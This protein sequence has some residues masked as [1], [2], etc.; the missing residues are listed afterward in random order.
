MEE[1]ENAHGKLPKGEMKL[2]YIS[3]YGFRTSF[4]TNNMRRF[5]NAALISSIMGNSPKTLIQFYT[6]T[7]TDMQ[8]ELIDNYVCIERTIS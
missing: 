2:S 5:P 1:Y 8:K 3:L 4:A 7:D 6:Q